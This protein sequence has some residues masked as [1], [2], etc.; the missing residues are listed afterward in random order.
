M[1]LIN[2]WFGDVEGVVWLW[3]ELGYIG[4]IIFREVVKVVSLGD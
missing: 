2:I 1:W 3:I 4:N